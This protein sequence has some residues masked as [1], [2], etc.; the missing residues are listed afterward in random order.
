M[1]KEDP[2]MGITERPGSFY[3]F[4]FSYRKHL[5]SDDPC[6]IYPK[7]KPYRY[8]DLPE[9]LAQQQHNCKYQQQ[10]W[11][12][13]DD[14]DQP[15]NSFIHPSPEISRESAQQDTQGK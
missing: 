10:G 5:A 15:E 6:Y 2:G 8:K 13:P 9:P 14:I 11:D 12:A 7:R 3:I 4:P 1:P